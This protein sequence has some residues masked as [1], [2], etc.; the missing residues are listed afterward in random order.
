MFVQQLNF[1]PLY[2]NNTWKE[3]R[4]ALLVGLRFAYFRQNLRWHSS[5]CTTVVLAGKAFFILGC[6][7]TVSKHNPS[8][9]FFI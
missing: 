1:E 4:K 2:E 5:H 3:E 9:L 8:F 7:G 6:A